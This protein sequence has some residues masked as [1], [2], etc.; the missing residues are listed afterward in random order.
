MGQAEQ[1]RTMWFRSDLGH[2]YVTARFDRYDGYLYLR[3][4]RCPDCSCVFI[5]KLEGYFNRFHAPITLIYVFLISR[6]QSGKWHP[7]ISRSYED[8]SSKRQT[9]NR[10]ELCF[11]Q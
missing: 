6:L 5:M 2:G 3:R 7:F 8:I 4:Y 1:I 10:Q 11:D 9:T